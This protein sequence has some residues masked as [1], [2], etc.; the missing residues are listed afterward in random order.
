MK[1]YYLP[2]LAALFLHACSP[3]RHVQSAEKVDSTAVDKSVVAVRDTVVRTVNQVVTQTVVEYYPLFDTVYIDRLV[4]QPVRR[5]TQTRIDTR[6]EEAKGQDSTVHRNIRV[7]TDRESE[8]ESEE[9]APAAVQSVKWVALSLL[10][11]LFI[12]IILKLKF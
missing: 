1:T 5:I 7:A 2:L 3:L 12:L 10:T 11:L 4:P 9:E 8:T 6:A